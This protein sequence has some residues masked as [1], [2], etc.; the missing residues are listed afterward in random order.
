MY[1]VA[2]G[3]LRY[4]DT[5]SSSGGPDEMD[6]LLTR[7]AKGAAHGEPASLNAEL[8][9]VTSQEA[10]PPLKEAATRSVGLR[11]ST[12]VPLSR[13]AG[14]VAAAPGLG[15]SWLYD[16]RTYLAE[17]FAD[18]HSSP[19]SELHSFDVGLGLYYPLS[20]RNWTP[21][22]GGGAAY[23]IQSFSEDGSANGLRLHGAAGILLGRLSTVQLRGELGYFINAF[24]ER[25]SSTGETALSHGPQL[26]LSLGF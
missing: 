13:A 24:T 20:R 7:L 17:L 1:E 18:F 3:N 11:L 15:I 12:I 14:D 2:K 26:L 10:E 22:V 5:L 25:A 6:T 19:S 9:T 4:D 23:A 21:Y 16:T 8:G